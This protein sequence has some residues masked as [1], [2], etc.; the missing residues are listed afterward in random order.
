M[1]G[2]GLLPRTGRTAAE[3]RTGGWLREHAVP[4]AALAGVAGLQ[5]AVLLIGDKTYFAAPDNTTQFFAWYQKEA[6]VLHS[7][8]FPVLW[9]ANTLS[10]HSFVGETQTGVFYPVNILWLLAFGSANGIGVRALDML[11]V[12]QFLV[13]SVGFYALARSFGVSRWPAAIAGI[14]FVYTGPVDG[15]AT[16][17]T[18]IF[19]GLT[20]VPWALFFAHRQLETTRLRFAVGAGAAIGLA[21]LAGHFQPPFHAALMV[22]IFYLLAGPRTGRSRRD[23]LAPRL[24]GAATTAAVAALVAAP[25]LAYSLPYLNRA[26]RFVGAGP[27]IPP[28][29]SVSFYIF[30]HLYT[31]GPD[32]VLSLLDPQ[33]YPIADGNS[34]YMGLTALAV[35]IVGGL[36]FSSAVRARMGRYRWALIAIA[37]IGIL[38]VLGPW[39]IFPAILYQLPLVTEVRE[40]GRYSIMIEVVLCLLLAFALEEIRARWATSSQATGKRW[41]RV[42]SVLGAAAAVDGIYLIF[43]EPPGG[44]HWFGIQLLLGGVTLLVLAF[45]ARLRSGWLIGALGALILISSLDNVSLTTDSTSSPL[46]PTHYYAR[47]PAITYAEH[48]CASGRTLVLY[49]ALPVNV[50]DV[51]RGLHTQN[52]YGATLQVPYFDFL[53]A[54]SWTSTEQTKLLDLRCIATRQPLALPG[55]RLAYR[56]RTGVEIYVNYDTSPLNTPALQPVFASNLSRGDRD[57]RYRFYLSRPTTVI[58]SALVYPGWKLE[59]DGRPAKASSYRVDGV[60]VFPEVS[61]GAGVHTLRYSWSGWPS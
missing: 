61:L 44:G 9:D 18:A 49:S 7:G 47:T 59:V 1:T 58:V 24:K 55:Y 30:S 56:D 3:P 11:V 28:G 50:G 45:G 39:T 16:G 43:R 8:G 2:T 60:P 41:V 27:P 21:V 20:L 52:G 32:S 53:S 25:Q 57:L 40:L 17:Q 14:V 4:L 15:R 6:A 35:L 13:G 23:E 37:L 26:Y 19:F 46:Y 54:S 22:A 10:G 33:Q 34:L 38:A 29:G 36:A 31:G 42:L 51:F 5:V 48:A 12:F